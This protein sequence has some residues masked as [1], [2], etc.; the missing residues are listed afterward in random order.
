MPK[1]YVLVGVPG[2]GKTT[3]IGHQN[4]DWTK[5]EMVS[6]DRFVEQYAAT[7]DKTYNEVFTE[8]MPTAVKLMSAQVIAARAAGKDIVWD[9]TSTTLK[10]R[11]KKFNMLPD[12]YA[13][14]VVFATPPREVLE[15]RLA[16]RPGKNIPMRV[17]TQMIEGYELPTRL[18]GFAEIQHGN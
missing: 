12:Y 10:S 2:A 8:Y 18:E 5:T 16:G 3:W 13:I 6:T 4:F 1:L 14:A 11:K 15:A 9:Q 17:M 7:Q